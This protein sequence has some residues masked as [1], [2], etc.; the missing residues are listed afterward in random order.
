[1][2]HEESEENLIKDDIPGT[3]RSGENTGAL[4]QNSSAQDLL[5][6]R[7]KPEQFSLR[8]SPIASSAFAFPDHSDIIG[9]HTQKLSEARCDTGR[10]NAS[11]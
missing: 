3:G 7:R 1:M 9:T 11:V 4:R 6:K 10:M 2:F 8:A 5:R